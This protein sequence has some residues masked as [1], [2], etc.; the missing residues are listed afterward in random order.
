MALLFADQRRFVIAGAT[1]AL[2]ACHKPAEP[3]G[4]CRCAPA[5]TIKSKPIGDAAPM[6]GETVLANLRRHARDVAAGRNPRDIKVLDDQ[7]RF[8]VVELCQPCGDWVNDRMTMEQLF[9]LARLDD[10][11]S[12]V[13]MGLVLRDGSTA[14]GDARPAS[15]R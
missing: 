5:N 7:L 3:E 2:A 11:V 4:P 14:Y 8:A 1:L 12:A 9:P 6:T 13:C 15:C 10:A